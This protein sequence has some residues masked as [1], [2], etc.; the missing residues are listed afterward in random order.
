MVFD[1]TMVTFQMTLLTNKFTNI[2]M[3][4]GKVHPLAKA[5]PSF[6]SNLWW[7]IVMDDWD[8]DVK[9]IAKWQ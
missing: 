2:V 5:I 1:V 9:S 3:D 8:L 7:N 6:V 4:G